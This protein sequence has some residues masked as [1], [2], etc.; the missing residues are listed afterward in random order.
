[1]TDF[2]RDWIAK[3]RELLDA[4]TEGPWWATRDMSPAD[5]FAGYGSADDVALATDIEEPADATLIA[6][7]RT[8]LPAALAALKAVMEEHPATR[9]GCITHYARSDCEC[10]PRFTCATCAVTHPCP[11]VAAIEVA[12]RGES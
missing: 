6:D 12:L 4:A 3:R 2:T 1:M 9:L 7:A 11:T 5:V 8:S 10:E